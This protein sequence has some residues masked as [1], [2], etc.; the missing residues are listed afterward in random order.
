MQGCTPAAVALVEE[1]LQVDPAAQVRHALDLPPLA[2]RLQL[3]LQ[4]M[5]CLSA[6]SVS[7][8]RACSLPV[9]K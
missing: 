6:M 7:Y 3:D 2:L 9:S 8:G 5:R 4:I 1:G